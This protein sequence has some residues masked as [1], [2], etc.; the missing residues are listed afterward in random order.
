MSCL[1]SWTSLLRLFLLPLLE[2]S[3][4]FLF[5]ELS[6]PTERPDLDFAFFCDCARSLDFPYLP[7]RLNYDRCP[8]W[9]L[10]SPLVPAW[11]DTIAA[12]TPPVGFTCV[13]KAHRPDSL[14]SAISVPLTS[15]LIVMGIPPEWT[16]QTHS[17]V[18]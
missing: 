1:S 12:F 14:S 17:M 7:T 16:T 18:N 13:H 10:W 5:L 3:L 4:H 8:T 2:W 9:L 6:F 11:G 15:D